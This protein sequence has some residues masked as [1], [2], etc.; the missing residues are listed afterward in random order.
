MEECGISVMSSEGEAAKDECDNDEDQ[1]IFG[2]ICQINLLLLLRVL[3]PFNLTSFAPIR[4]LSEASLSSVIWGTGITIFSSLPVCN[5]S[6]SE[7]DIAT[8]L[9]RYSE[10]TVLTRLQE[11]ANF[12]GA[13]IDWERLVKTS[14]TGISDAREYQMLWRH[15]AYRGALLDGLEDDAKP[16]DDDRDLEFDLEVTPAVSHETSAEV[17]ACVKTIADNASFEASLT[18][19]ALNSQSSRGCSESLQTPSGTAVPNSVQGQPLPTF[20]CAGGVYGTMAQ[21]KKRKPWSKAEDLELIA[22]VQKFGEGNWA[23]T[24]KGDYKGDRTA[25]Q[26]SQVVFTPSSNLHGVFDFININARELTLTKEM[27][28]C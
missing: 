24:L 3:T 8:L 10:A 4:K 25:S 19:N 28:R 23:N 17:A 9:Q 1:I 22:A 6:A 13:N 15:L 7:E 26:L 21:K 14:S 20:S 2:V 5:F 27:V 12:S 18:R 16:L 11:V